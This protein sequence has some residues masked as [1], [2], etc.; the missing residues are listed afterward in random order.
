[1]PAKQTGAELSSIRPRDKID[2]NNDRRCGAFLKEETVEEIRLNKYLAE[3]GGLSRRQADRLIEEGGVLVDGVP[4]DVGMRVTGK[5]EITLLNGAQL[6][7]RKP[8]MVIIALNKPRGVVSTT[9]SFKNETN[10]LS[11]VPYK[12]RLYPVGRLDKDS[13]VLIFLTNDGDFMKAVTDAAGK[14][15]KEYEVHVDREIGDDQLKKLAGGLYLAE[16]NKKT[17]PCRVVRTGQ[18]SFRIVLT[19]GLNRQIRRMCLSLGLRV[20]ALRRVRIMSVG[21]SGLKEGEWRVL[22]RKEQNALRREAGLS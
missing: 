8:E 21:L 13:S 3:H 10:V 9:R 11:L 1:M 7:E 20:T 22:T 2:M 19:Q 17:A 18:R 15:E 6:T 12:D 14:H 16:L 4:A 5:E